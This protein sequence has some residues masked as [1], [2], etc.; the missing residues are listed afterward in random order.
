MTLLRVVCVLLVCL[1]CARASADGGTPLRRFALTVAAN[2]GGVA[3]EPL[4]FAE[5]DAR[6]VSDVLEQLGGLD[7]ADTVR[8]TQPSAREL[9]LAF[10][11]LRARVRA[12]LSAGARTE[13]IFY[14][15]GHSDDTS[16]LL[17]NDRLDYSAL[18]ALL[19][20]LPAQVRIGILDSCASGAFTREKGGVRRPPFMVDASTE[21]HG[22][23]FLTSSSADEAAQESDRIGGSF[24]TH[25][26]VSGLRGAADASGDRKITLT[27]AYRFAF[28]E[29]LAR[30]A[31]TQYGSQHPAY[32]IRLAGTGDLVMTDLRSTQAELVLD[33]TVAGRVF[34]WD[35]QHKL[36]IEV[37][38]PRG[39]RVRLALPPGQY[40][41]EL[42]E[43]ARFSLA[44]R[45]QAIA[46]Q[47]NVVGETSFHTVAREQTLARGVVEH[48]VEHPFAAGA[49]PPVSTNS[50][51]RALHRLPVRNHVDVA[52]LYDDP[53]AVSGLQLGL[54]GVTAVRYLKGVQLGLFFTDSAELL[55]LQLSGVANVA[56]SF[57]TGLQATLGVN[58]AGVATHGVQ[59]SGLVNYGE[60]LYGAQLGLG[61]NF[62]EQRGYGL[63]LASLNLAASMI[64]AQLGFVNLAYHVDGLQA[65]GLNVTTGRVHGVQ[66]GLLNYAD[67]ADVSI[68]LIGITRKGGTHLQLSFDEM[69]APE[70]LLRLDANYNY[71]FVSVAIAP[72]DGQTR[73]YAIGAGLG[74]KAPLFVPKLWLDVDYGFHMLQSFDGYQRRVPNSL[75]RLRALVRYELYPHLSV[76]AGLSFNVY[77]ELSPERRF[78]PAVLV[79]P[80]RATPGSA[81]VVYWPGFT[82][83]VRL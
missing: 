8:L 32:E 77:A 40:R 1:L 4:Q 26:L 55:G 10:D 58:Y 53:D 22:H 68:G 18:R 33:E 50:R 38:K 61:V 62:A 72:Y 45:A 56:R 14:Y 64:G 66:A 65:G 28:E 74:V 63:Q 9:A 25:Y 75:H 11:Q 30:T 16:L 29:T 23:A 46:G 52:A 47:D 41:L 12:A 73:G 81:E 49:I 2:D 42:S 7:P 17:G 71:S 34:V 20:G 80:H 39:R 78:R 51:A 27:E 79:Q 13:V 59:A 60:Q 54:F 21:V 43:G 36:T 48:F 70:I 35:T 44:S 67:E 5:R 15:S 83:G 57:Q 69:F 37:D 6:A 19:D 31:R 82:V 76:F 3:R 24:F